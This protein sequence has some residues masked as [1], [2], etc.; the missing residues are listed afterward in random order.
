MFYIHRRSHGLGR[1]CA[2]A[3]SDSA[4]T[5][6]YVSW[7]GGTEAASWSFYSSL[8]SASENSLLL[9]STRRIGFGIVYTILSYQKRLV[10]EAVAANC[11]TLANP[12]LI[13]T[14]IPG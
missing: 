4:P 6:Y 9:G 5:T 11:S 1:R 12:T 7:T 10:V 13:G 2:Y 8:L 3:H 14:L